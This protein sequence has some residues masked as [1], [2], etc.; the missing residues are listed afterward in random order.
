MVTSLCFPRL[1]EANQTVSTPDIRELLQR[2]GGGDREARR[3]LIALLGDEERLGSV[4]LAMARNRLPP[5]HR[6]RRLLDSRDVV[7]SALRTALDQ[8][9]AFKG[10]TE[11][12][13]YGW[14]AKIIRS[15]ISRAVRTIDKA[16]PTGWSKESQEPLEG[17]IAE[18][19]IEKLQAAIRQLPFDQRLVVELRLRKL[20]S[21]ESATI[22]G[23]KPATVRKREERAI[24]NLRKLFQ[25]SGWG[26][27]D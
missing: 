27:R 8:F 14:L 24:G 18:G 1:G 7:Q 3:E 21:N 10:E 4:L 17:L 16:Y 23:L 15:K 2:I 11:G 6:A 19:V 9:S 5:G 22:L 20:N 25:A 26:P 12:N 13:L